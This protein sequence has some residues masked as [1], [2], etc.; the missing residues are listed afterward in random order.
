[1]NSICQI[2]LHYKEHCSNILFQLKQR[3]TC[4]CFHLVASEKLSSMP[5]PPMSDTESAAQLQVH[6]C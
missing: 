2:C 1:M 4:C 3:Y 6:A 5:P